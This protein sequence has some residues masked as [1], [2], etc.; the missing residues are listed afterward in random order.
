MKKLLVLVTILTLSITIGHTQTKAY[1][2]KKTKEFY[3]T[4]NIKQDHKIFG[5][6]LPDVKS[7]K[8]IL[9]SVFTNDVKDNP[10]KLPLGAYYETSNLQEGD[11]IRFVSVAGEFVKLHFITK[12]KKITPF[13]IGRKYIV[14]E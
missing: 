7:K 1:V 6:A 5:Y 3:L 2:D 10:Y 8:L 13:Y 4:A 14:F 11:K 12:D 9:F